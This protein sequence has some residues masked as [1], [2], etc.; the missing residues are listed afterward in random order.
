MYTISA[1]LWEMVK[2]LDIVGIL[3]CGQL[4]VKFIPIY[5]FYTFSCNF[6]KRIQVLFWIYSNHNM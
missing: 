5:S 3:D 6:F 4:F 1:K 2:S